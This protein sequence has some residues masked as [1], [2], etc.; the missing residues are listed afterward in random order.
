MSEDDIND[1]RQRMERMLT[2]LVKAVWAFLMGA[3]IIGG[4]WA[5]ALFRIGLLETDTKAQTVRLTSH[6]HDLAEHDKD[7]ALIKRI[8]KF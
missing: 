4:C 2:Q 7:I 3:F 5:V 8:I 1:Y 6:D